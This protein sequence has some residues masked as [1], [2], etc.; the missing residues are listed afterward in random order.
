[1]S[2]RL[3]YLAWI[4]LLLNLSCLPATSGEPGAKP[5]PAPPSSSASA[6]TLPVLELGDKRLQ[7]ELACTPAEQ[8]RGLMFRRELA[9]DKGMLFVFAS[10]RPLSF[11]MK[12]TYLA[13]SIAY[14]D[15]AGKIVDLQDMQPLDETS[16]PSAKPARYALEVNQGWF[17]RHG[18][19]VGQQIRLDSFCAH[20]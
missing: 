2:K 8:Q 19:S 4:G 18:V 3:R 20:P 1:M 16:H 10:E 11:W 17:R 12:N 5:S 6:S 15:A 14:L 13:L 9:E 7:I